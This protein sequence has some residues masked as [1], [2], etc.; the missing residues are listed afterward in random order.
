MTQIDVAGLN[1][2]FQQAVEHHRAGRLA[3]AERLYRDIL[4]VRV[5]PHSLSL[6]GLIARAAGEGEAALALTDQAITLKPDV[7]EFHNNRGNVLRDL[8]RHEEA[9]AAL[10]QAVALDAGTVAI[11]I[12][13]GAALL[14]AKRIDEA[15][16]VL[17][18]A[19]GPPPGGPPPPFFPRPPPPPPPGQSR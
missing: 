14:D 16:A 10:G 8:G 7:A 12:N 9:A 17:E 3:E 19:G 18:E 1:Q 15:C 4:A 13:Y 2:T 5:E 11:R 6:L